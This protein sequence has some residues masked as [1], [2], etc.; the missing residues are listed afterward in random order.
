MEPEEVVDF[1]FSSVDVVNKI[2]MKVCIFIFYVCIFITL[3]FDRIS[4]CLA[5]FFDKFSNN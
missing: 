1:N 4:Q 3:H 2:I 5:K